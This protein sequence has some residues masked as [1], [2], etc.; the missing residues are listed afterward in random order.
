M[1]LKKLKFVKITYLTKRERKKKHFGWMIL[2][3]KLR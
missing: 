3:Q 1:E 2:D